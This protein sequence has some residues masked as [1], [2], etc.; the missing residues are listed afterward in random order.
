MS[1]FFLSRPIFAAVLSAVILTIGIAAIPGLP[2]SQFPQI[3]PPTIVVSSSYPGANAEEVESAVTTPIEEAINGSQGL[4]Y[5]TSTSGDDG[6]STITATFNLSRDIDK[7]ATDVLVAIQTASGEIPAVVKTEGV[8]VSKTLG[9]L[10]MSVSLF[11]DNPKYDPV[12]LSNYASL[13]VVDPLKRISGVGTVTIFG[14]RTYA[15]RIWL[16]PKKLSD[17]G[18]TTGEVE[19]AL[20][21]QNVQVPAGAFGQEPTPKGQPY[22]ISVLV[23]GQLA[24]AQQF[25]N[26]ILR[27]TAQGGYVRIRDV[28]YAQLGADSYT[29]SSLRNGKLNIG[30][31][32]QQLPSAN[33]L[34]VSAAVLKEMSVLGQRFPP[35][36]HW[37]LNFDTTDFV[38]ES[39]REVVVTLLFSILLVVLVIF[40]FLQDW[41]TTLIPAITIPVSLVGT[42]GLISALGFSINTLTLFGLTLATGLVVDDAIVVIENITRFMSLREDGDKRAAAQGAMKEITGAVVATSLVLLA[43][44]IPVGF[45]PGT[46]GELYKQF[47]LTIASSIAISLFVALTLTPALSVLLIPAG[48]E[49]E[50]G[51]FIFGPINRAIAAARRT[52]EKFLNAILP[53]KWIVALIFVASLALTLFVFTSTP[54]GFLPDEDQG[55]IYVTIQLPEGS[56][57]EQEEAVGKRVDTIA[58]KMPGVALVFD[59]SGRGPGTTGNGTNLGFV[60]LRLAPWS[61]RTA[62]SEQVSGIIAALRPK[63]AAIPSAQVL[64]F[65]PPAVQGIGSLGGFQYELEDPGNG[66]F[67]PLTATATKLIDAANRS[68]HVVAAN[69]TFAE[70]APHYVI[71]VDRDKAE[72]AGVNVGTIFDALQS[73][74]GSEYINDFTYGNRVYHVYIQAAA[75]DRSRFED[76]QKIFVQSSTGQ[77]TPITSFINTSFVTSPP[78][79]THYNLFRDIEITGQTPAGQGSGQSLGE[80]ERLSNTIL[81]PFAHEWSGISLEQIQGGGA[82][83]LIFGLGLLFVFFVLAAQY[84][85]LSEP[86]IILLATPVAILGALVGLQL[87]GISSDVYAQVGYVLLI[88]LASKNAILIVE[89][90]NQLREQGLGAVEAVTRAAETR[91]RPILMT[92]FAFILGIVPL[93]F[94]SGAGAA[95]RHSLGTAVFGGML[96]STVLNLGIIPALYIIV[97]QFDRSHDA[98]VPPGADADFKGTI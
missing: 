76:L 82:A 85:S 30:L 22:Y 75:N 29:S 4:N 27:S 45:F 17:N 97:A 21:A 50:K 59:I 90:A 31:G 20:L 18:L 12:F 23:A 32:I 88:G 93:V 89:F 95:S 73:Q 91:L 26:V 24:T 14:Q 72:A 34:Q 3:A 41:R 43:V 1:S 16:D 13:Q 64:A 38:R 2:I 39:I 86:F 28:G 40:I 70:S 10:L 69:T 33:A 63:L 87:R 51:G 96:V 15:M 48:A 46:T 57:L 81:G 65:N 35:G 37:G 47:A 56:S 7:A 61:A 84:E 66:G 36:V 74:I 19:S 52:Y 53:F 79:V 8:T 11:S 98:K 49:A 60:V 68:G 42:F 67:G 55:I 54:T 78:I 83:A 94:A 5:I 58:R 92:S 25:E 62:P 6:S 9:S 80:M 44:F 71:T 77:A